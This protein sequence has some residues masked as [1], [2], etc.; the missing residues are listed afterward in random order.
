M[1]SYFFIK[2]KASY[3]RRKDVGH[4]SYRER[5][6]GRPFLKI[7]LNDDETNCEMMA[8]LHESR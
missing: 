6:M 4:T 5:D 7:Q 8:Q 2:K 1:A 3:A